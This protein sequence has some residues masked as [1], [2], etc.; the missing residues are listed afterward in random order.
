MRELV[1]ADYAVIAAFFAVMVGVGV[2]YSRRAK[3]DAQFF[4]S[5]KSVPWW[6]SG[7][8]FYM[9]SF[10]AL[11]FVMYSA[12][13]YKFGWVPVTVSWLSVPAVLLG[14]WFLAVRWRRAAKGSPIDYIATRYTPGMC[15][16][17]AVLGLPMQLLDNALKLLA[18]GTVVG[19]GMGFPLFWSICISGV[20][21]VLYTFL[22]GLKA[23]LVC[24]FIQ[25]F[26]ILAVVF[27]LPPLCLGRLAALDGGTGLVHGFKV[28]LDRVPDGFFSFTNGKYGWTYM[29]VFFC[30]VGSTL[31]T[32]WS[33]VQRY[34]TTKSEKDAKKMAYLVAALLFLGPPLFFFPAMAARVFMPELDMGNSEAMNAV[35]ATVCKSILPAGMI[36]MV[37]AAMFSAT[38][39]SLAGNFNAAA[40]VMV[41]KAATPRRRMFAARGATVLV[42]GA[43]VA[44]TFVMQYAQGAKDLFDVT[45]KMFGVFLPP[46]AIPMLAGVFV[47]RLSRRAGMVALVGGMAVG[48]ALFLM[49]AAYPFL[50]EFE[51]IF[52]LTGVATLVFIALG[53][54]LFPDKPEERAEVDAFFKQLS[55]DR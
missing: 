2:Y 8:S 44:L 19:V 18:I 15:R 31:S 53:T 9:N 22:G 30:A 48:V 38:M 42:G 14:A 39:S 21:I 4:G 46:I 25:F 41:D 36:G 16:T 27:A 49:G 12:L 40:S 17:L 29:L 51:W 28:F 43:V 32:N 20:I 47:R 55:G 52:S 33:L 6:L 10:S 7:V 45:N 24:D 1:L 34:Y 5:D 11:A 26:V 35:Y 13:A 37:I 50:R 54:A 3:S 23:T